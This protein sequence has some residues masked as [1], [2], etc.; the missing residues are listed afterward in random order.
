MGLPTSGS[1]GL[2]PRSISGLLGRHCFF[3]EYIQGMVV[4][5]KVGVGLGAIALVLAVALCVSGE[6]AGCGT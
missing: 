6:N 3:A 1:L 4:R 5:R 2:W